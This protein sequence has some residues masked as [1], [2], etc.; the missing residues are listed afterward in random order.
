MSTLK[1]IIQN[2]QVFLRE[3]AD[4][5]D[6]TA[7]DVVPVP[8][9]EILGIPDEQWPTDPDGISRL[10]ARM[11]QIEPLIM[12]AEEEAD[13]AAWREKIKEYTIA[14]MHK[15]VDGIFE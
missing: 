15:R 14:N 4:L 8:H 2:G 10:L 11:E 5:P 6:G 13:T 7:V 9:E 12:T 1:G 3:P